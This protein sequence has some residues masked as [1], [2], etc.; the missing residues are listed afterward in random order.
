MST[1]GVG[2]G[3][4]LPSAY[5]LPSSGDDFMYRDFQ[6]GQKIAVQ[7]GDQL[8]TDTISSVRYTSPTAA[9]WPELSWWQQ[10]KRSL[11]PQ[12]WRKP[13]KPIRESEPAGMQI[14]TVK[15]DE[16]AHRDRIYAQ[17]VRVNE[18]L[19]ELGLNEPDT[20]NGGMDGH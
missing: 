19:G 20:E 2:R 4:W 5:R 18:F 13:L 17:A 10:V 14:R 3:G 12:R 6:P 11:T 16:Q 8:Y 7:V 9:I 15:D 1:D